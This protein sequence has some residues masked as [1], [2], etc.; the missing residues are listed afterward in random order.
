[1]GYV[2]IK[3]VH[4]LITTDFPFFFFLINTA[5][6]IQQCDLSYPFHRFLF[7]Q[8][9]IKILFLLDRE[10][11]K[12]RRK[13]YTSS[14]Q[15]QFIK[16]IPANTFYRFLCFM[17]RRLR[18]TTKAMAINEYNSNRQLTQYYVYKYVYNIV[19]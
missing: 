6:N 14:H 10:K 18:A 2:Y 5:C 1:M 19:L 12:R 7:F 4:T 8:S 13:N 9:L 15:F 16:L 11:K 3:Y 17:T